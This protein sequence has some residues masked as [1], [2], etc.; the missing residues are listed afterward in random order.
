MDLNSGET[1]KLVG[2]LWFYEGKDVDG[3][4][5]GLKNQGWEK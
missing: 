1:G 2:R 4:L 3:F 5:A